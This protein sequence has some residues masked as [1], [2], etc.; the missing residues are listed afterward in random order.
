MRGL[1]AKCLVGGKRC[2]PLGSCRHFLDDNSGM[3]LIYTGLILGILFGVGGLAVDAGMWYATKRSAQSAADAAALAAA[4][5]VARG[6]T[7]TEVEARAKAD[8][9]SNGYSDASG[10]TITIN[11]P[12]TSG[13]SAGVASAVEAIVQ[14][15][16]PSFL[17]AVIRSEQVTVAAR[18]VASYRMAESCIYVMDP[19]EDSALSVPGTADVNMDC[20]AQV[21]SVSAIAIDQVGSSCMTATSLA[22]AGG[23]SG[24]CLDPS[25]DEDMPQ[26]E[27]PFSYLAPPA[28]ASA[29]CDYT[30]LVTVSS[31]TTLS[32]GNYCGGLRITA[33]VDFSP[34]EY[35][36]G[37]EGLQIQGNSV[38]TGDEVSFYFPD[39]VTGY[40]PGPGGPRSLY[41][42]G[43]TDLQL[44]APT[45]GD[46]QGV[47]FYQDQN[48]DPD[49]E[50]VLQ[51]GADMDLEGV[52]YAINNHMRFA[53]GSD[54][55]DGWVVIVVD[56]IEFTGNSNISGASTPM[57][58]PLA[59]IQPT[60][61]E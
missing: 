54:G 21:N 35:V 57:D 45:T 3:T 20:G 5:E 47:L 26:T 13:P 49:L 12:P 8:A 36:M 59:L 7:A 34:G 28:A 25:P 4:L 17:S 1:L 23:A 46:Y 27:D 31:A 56:T 61:V 53:G 37:G 42:A 18:A 60:L 52:I 41:I 14:Q 51:G 15:P 22:T 44:S 58:L 33:D 32:P 19:S 10:A 6:S 30:S 43:T 55:I 11:N 50:I 24:T 16:V 48:I 2:D 39:T 38:V 29:P 9:E 40:D